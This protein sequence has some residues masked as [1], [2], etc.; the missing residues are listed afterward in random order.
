MKLCKLDVEKKS[1]ILTL[2]VFHVITLGAS[3]FMGPFDSPD[4]RAIS[5][6]QRLHKNQRTS[7]VRAI[8]YRHVTCFGN[9]VREARL[10]LAAEE[11]PTPPNDAMHFSYLKAESI[12]IHWPVKSNSS[13]Q[14]PHHSKQEP[15]M[16]P[17]RFLVLV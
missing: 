6:K 11:H 17:S 7:V 12:D 2:E 15:P 1:S 16:Q 9:R 13:T 10:L 5:S 3:G 4:P 8:N 14:L